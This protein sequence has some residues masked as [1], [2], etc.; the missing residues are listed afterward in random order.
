MRLAT[1]N[2]KGGVRKTASAVYVAAGLHVADRRRSPAEAGAA[3]AK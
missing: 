2:L 3:Q 1:V